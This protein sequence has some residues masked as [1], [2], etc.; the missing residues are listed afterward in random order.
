MCDHCGCNTKL[1]PLKKVVLDLNINI[2]AKNDY[3]AEKNRETFANSNLFAINLI[4]SPGTGKTTLLETTLKALKKKFKF[5]VIEG[6]LQTDNDKKRIE[7]QKVPVRQINTDSACHLDAQM[8]Q[9]E[10]T[11]FD[12]KAL[13]LLF[14]EN[15]GNLV[16]PA[17]FDLG[18]N[19][20]V[21]LLSVTEGDD[22]PEKYP[23]LFH[24]AS[25]ALI[26][27]IDLA[28]HTNFSIKKCRAHL[29]RINPKIEIIEISATK[30][31]GMNKWYKWLESKIQVR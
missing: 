19:T 7:K 6:D 26:T 21:A 22:K 8:I 3:F 4:S 20:K 23:I 30:D 12:L 17:S 29:K 14:I 1:K 11:H 9:N 18:E 28:K 10:L 2:K 24:E 13:D 25:V 31:K 15:V 27:K 5:A 16:C